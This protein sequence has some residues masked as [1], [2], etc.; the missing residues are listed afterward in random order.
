MTPSTST[1]SGQQDKTPSFLGHIRHNEYHFRTIAIYSDPADVANAV[2]LLNQEGF[3]PEQISLLGQEQDG[4][5][6]KLE[7]EW[8]IAHT[9]KGAAVGAALGLLP[10]LALVSGVVLSGGIGVLASGPMLIALESLGFGAL[11]GGL[12]GGFV[13]NLDSAE[14]PTHI[15]EEIE[16]A[17]GRGQWVVVVHSHDKTEAIHAQ[18]LLPDSRIAREPN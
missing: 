16:D 13:N 12:I 4:W 11:G 5:Q 6:E 18:S 2:T 7:L 9:A 14:K 15:K 17:V 10:G 8:Q 3:T 1:S